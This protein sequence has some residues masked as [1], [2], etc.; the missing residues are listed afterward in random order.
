MKEFNEEYLNHIKQIIEHMFVDG[1][2]IVD[3]IPSLQQHAQNA[4]GF[5]A[6]R[7]DNALMAMRPEQLSVAQFIELTNLLALF[8]EVD[9]VARLLYVVDM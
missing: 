1:E 6:R 7:G 4:P 2:Q 8:E 5:C 9:N 3:V